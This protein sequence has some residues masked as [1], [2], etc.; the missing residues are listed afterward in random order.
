M[1]FIVFYSRTPLVFSTPG[2]DRV[3]QISAGANNGHRGDN[4]DRVCGSWR[5]HTCAVMQ[6]GGL[7][8]WGDNS[9]AAGRL[10]ETALG[11]ARSG[12]VALCSGTAGCK[13][14]A[15]E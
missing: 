1:Y 12:T 11:S 10:A 8:C 2:G 15:H 13:P 4:A 5:T 7:K 6:S 9:R 14:C 3:V